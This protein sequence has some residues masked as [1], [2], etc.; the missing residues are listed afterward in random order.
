[1]PACEA[2][3]YVNCLTSRHASCCLQLHTAIVHLESHF[4][5]WH[6]QMKS[7]ELQENRCNWRLMRSGECPHWLSKGVSGLR[8]CPP[9]FMRARNG[10]VGSFYG[11]GSNFQLEEPMT[12]I[13]VVIERHLFGIKAVTRGD[14]LPIERLLVM[15]MEIASRTCNNVRNFIV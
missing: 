12:I 2:L 8:W 4:P 1:M 14:H 10:E 5:R 9:L 3:V 11:I 6:E 15:Q 13:A 7:M